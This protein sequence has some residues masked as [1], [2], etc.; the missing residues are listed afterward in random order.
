MKEKVI[1][2]FN[3]QINREMYSS[4]LYLQFANIYTEKGLDGFA[5]WFDI[6]AQE[7]H[8]HA[9]LMIKF[10]HNNGAKVV[11]EEIKKPVVENEGTIEVIQAA[12]AH[13]RY[14][15]E[16]IN[17]IYSEANEEKDYRTLQFLDWFVKE[18]GEEEKSAEDL[19]KK[20]EIF[21]KDPKSLYL[22]DKEL[23]A[24]TYSAPSLVL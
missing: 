21:G 22:L 6:Q 9:M 4:Y 20:M 15:T 1:A 11:Y 8:D 17:R 2:L 24:R 18:Q 16:S 12:L 3:E 23:A 19:L 13:E 14:I 10:L 7:E 5:N